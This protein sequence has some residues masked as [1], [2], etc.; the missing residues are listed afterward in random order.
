MS[1]EFSTKS[2]LKLATCHPDLQVIM[3]AAIKAS[4]VDFGIAEGHRSL[5]KQ[6][7]YFRTGKSKLNG[8]TSKSKH[9][10]MP[11]EAVDIY[12]YVNGKAD[13]SQTSLCFLG[14][15]ICGIAADL[16]ER[17]EVMYRLR[18]GGNW[19]KDGEVITDQSF[20]DLPHFELY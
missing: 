13:Y 14:G 11:S 8:T 20:D 2:K 6:L 7:E 10:G 16:F 3:N 18:W 1:Y 9:Q 5:E 12:P 4:Q 19:D 15:L 17:G